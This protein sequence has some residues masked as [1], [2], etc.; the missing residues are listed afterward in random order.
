MCGSFPTLA[1]P[2]RSLNADPQGHR[3]RQQRPDDSRAA[4]RANPAAVAQASG[5]ERAPVDGDVRL[6]A[7]DRTP[8]HRAV[9]AG[10]PGL[11]G[12][13]WGAH[14]QPVA[15]RAEPS[16]QSRGGA[17]TEASHGPVGGAT[18]ARGHDR[19]PGRRHQHPGDRAVYQGAVRHDGSDQRLRHCA[20]ADGR[21]TSD[22]D[23]HR[24]PV[25]P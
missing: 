23:S 8:R 3:P 16:I 4:S 6:L 10:R 7:H 5:D 19:V 22:G 24:R 21:A 14:R 20:G 9:G 25:G 17:S 11:F 15:Q 12:D 18:A 2:I 13:R 1:K